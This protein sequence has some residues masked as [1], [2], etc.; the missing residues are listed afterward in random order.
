MSD[1]RLERE[2]EF[3]NKV[4]GDSRRM[5][6]KEL[7]SYYAICS[8][9]A[10]YRR[11]VDDHAGAGR[12]V[13]E[14]GCG[15]GSL[16]YHLAKSGA[17][18]TGIDLSDV[19]IRKA[20]ERAARQQIAG[21]DFRVMNAEELDLEDARFDLICGV[22]ILHHLDLGKAYP[23]LARVLKPGGRAIFLEPLGH[24]P[25]INLFRKAT[26]HLRTVDEHPL[27]ISDL[28]RARA[29]FGDLDARFFHLH[30]L[31]ALPFRNAPFV[32]KLGR[33]LDAVDRV[34]FRCIPPLR[35]YAWQVVITLSRPIRS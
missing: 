18:I 5:G 9:F 24:N 26:P 14:Y 8:S 29:Y 15:E 22:A 32:G 7:D 16:A 31:L 20:E 1:V 10:H 17:S 4:F 25:L 30:T 21:I 3:H 23:E 13:L 34:A 28:G 19:A 2:R 6:R 35:R 11:V 27:L 33:S 12:S